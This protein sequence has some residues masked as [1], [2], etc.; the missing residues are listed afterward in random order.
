MDY[1]RF[2]VMLDC[3]RNAVMRVSE[4]KKLID[5]MQKIGYNALELYTED[6]YEVEGEPYFGYLRG[7]YTSQ[8]IQEIDA[9]AKARGIELIPCVQTLAHF[10]NL[11]TLP[12]YA[13]IVDVNDILLA[14]EE[15][16]YALLSKI[17]ET[18]AKNF[19][20]RSVNIGMDEAHLVGL[21]KYL[22][23][24]GYQNRFEILTR[25]LN[26]VVEIAAQYGFTP[27]MWSDM[28]FRLANNGD[29]Y[30]E[31][32][33]EARIREQV[34]E[35]LSLTLWSYYHTEKAHYDRFF[36]M[37]RAFQRDIWFAGGLWKWQG[38]APLNRHSLDTIKPA[39]QSVRENGIKNVL[40]TLWG[41]NGGECSPYT[42]LP[43][44][45]AVKRYAE[46]EFDDE[47]VKTEFQALFGLRFDDFFLLDRLNETPA[48][49]VGRVQAP[50]KSLLYNDCFLGILDED[51]RAEGHIPY[52][53]HTKA[54][55]EAATRAGEYAYVFDT[56]SAL[57]RVMELKAELG[58]RTR[59][60][61]QRKDIAALLELIQ[62]YEET[63]LR[64]DTFRATFKKQWD[65]ENKPFGWE[66]QE[67]RLA[68]VKARLLACRE[69]LSRYV[70]GELTQIEELEE[71]LL[72]YGKGYLRVDLYRE[73]VT[74][75]QL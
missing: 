10:T 62:D 52:E 53:Q 35:K 1:E 59:D 27:H 11:V 38:F 18:L 44:L 4:V 73:L 8:E 29:Y 19:T 37:H 47:I 12:A 60:A 68:G 28:F 55:R 22:D 41:D 2:G 69:T 66:V 16:T 26:K 64:L 6:T 54:I 34:P 39:M 15:K 75:G 63:A 51:L 40:I 70:A 56:L 33:P 48:Q 57:S 3:S 21:G 30:G 5:V 61:Y 7:R 24:H 20:S 49:P 45:Y 9:Y 50:C 67:I 17:F 42:L 46:G 74:R 58:I 14:D 32:L 23:K 71:K 13:D 25:H 65:K 43:S 31:T 36:Q 72:P